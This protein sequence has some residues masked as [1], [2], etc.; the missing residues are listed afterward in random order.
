MNLDNALEIMYKCANDAAVDQFDIIASNSED[1]SVT[2]YKGKVK[3]TEI[4]SSQG[5][6]IRIFHEGRP[7][8]SFTRS[9]SDTALRQCIKDAKELSRF[10]AKVDFQLPS[11]APIDN[12][13]LQLWNDD[14]ENITSAELL[15]LSFEIE[16]NAEKSHKL[17]ENVLSSAAGKSASRFS[18]LNSNGLRWNSRRN[19]AMAGVSLVAAKGDIKK[20]GAKYKGSRNF[21]DFDAS[22]LAAVAAEKAV[23]LLD[24]QAIPAGTYPVMFDNYMSAG[25][26]KPFMSA[27]YANTVQKG[28]SKLKDKVGEI[29]AS[30]CLSLYNDPFVIGMPG[31]GLID[32]E[33]VHAQKFD[34]IKKGRLLTYLYNLESAHKAGRSS[35]GSGNRSYTGKAGT[36]FDNLFVEKGNRSR[37]EILN[38]LDKCLLVTKFEGSG[39][40]SATSGEISLGIQGFLYEKGVMVQA[41]D[42]VTISGNYFE[43][44]KEIS[45]FSN[46]YNESFSASKVPDMLISKMTISC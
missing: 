5:I 10:S 28:Q 13:N 45:E 17:V 22:K 32:S 18:L 11:V 42:R 1:C 38:S 19:S 24:A 4:S 25:I 21:A 35:T 36:G 15:E 30:D 14:L 31:S 46:E 40:R 33:G 20:S 27:I 39:I 3:E 37:Q 6:G 7:G 12:R 23:G 34:V 43:L 41:V 8:Y 9:F 16:K 29:I 26:I 44:L 2:V